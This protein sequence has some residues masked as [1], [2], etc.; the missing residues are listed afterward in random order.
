MA[1]GTLR[2]PYLLHT[3]ASRTSMTHR[4]VTGT[5]VNILGGSQYVYTHTISAPERFPFPFTRLR[6]RRRRRRRRR[7]LA[8]LLDGS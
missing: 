2:L 7:T 6:R 8:T 5:A 3:P 1:Y 4:S